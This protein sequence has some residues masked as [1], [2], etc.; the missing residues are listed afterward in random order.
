MKAGGA[1]VAALI[2]WSAL[3]ETSK[4]VDGSSALLVYGSVEFP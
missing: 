3:T 1:T 4:A 2:T